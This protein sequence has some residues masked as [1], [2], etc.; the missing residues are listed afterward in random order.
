MSAWRQW[1]RRVGRE[2]RPRHGSL[3]SVQRQAEQ[4]PGRQGRAARKQELLV[5]NINHL[6]GSVADTLNEARRLRDG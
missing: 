6:A 3:L 1:P 2:L 5:L 4:Q